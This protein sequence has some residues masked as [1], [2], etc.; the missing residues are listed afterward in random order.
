MSVKS[1]KLSPGSPRPIAPWLSLDT[2]G[3]LFIGVLCLAYAPLLVRLGRWLWNREHYSFFP[4]G[5][6]AV[7]GLLVSALAEPGDVLSSR[8]LRSVLL[9]VAFLLLLVATLFVSPWLCGVSAMFLLLGM[10]YAVGGPEVTKKA[11]PAWLLLWMLV[12]IPLSLDQELIVSL[13]HFATRLSS[14]ILDWMGYR[15]IVNGVVLRL[16]ERIYQVEEACSGVQSLFS[17]LFCTG[18]YLILNRAGIIRSLLLIS[19]TFFWVMVAN[20]GR[21]VCV[22][23]LKES[24]D[25]PVDQ[26]FYHA[27]LGFVFF[28]MTLV[29]I[30][31]TE[32]LF[33]FVWP[34]LVLPYWEYRADQKAVAP[35]KRSWR[36]KPLSD[37]FGPIEFNVVIAMFGLV[38]AA[39]CV[40]IALG[41]SM[42]GPSLSDIEVLASQGQSTIPEEIEG[43]K[44]TQYQYIKRQSGDVNGETS[45]LWILEKD[46]RRIE[47]SIDG[48]YTN[49]WHYL[50]DCYRGQGW[51]DGGTTYTSY[52]DIGED[53]GGDFLWFNVAKQPEEH[54]IVVTGL[55]DSENRAFV[56]PQVKKMQRHYGRLNDLKERV[57]SLFGMGDQTI[58][59]SD[60]TSYQIQ[61]FYHGANPVTDEDRQQCIELFHSLRKH[62]TNVE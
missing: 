62:I 30:F 12:P 32:R 16:P 29:A 49:G 5:I 7:T 23:T 9:R 10:I 8:W 15:H 40:S 17:A 41:G 6:L 59:R 44:Q 56:A 52:R 51:K 46:G 48:P 55:F 47:A 57:A 36:Q 45:K 33:N 42:A 26:G 50:S 11:L 19:T 13:Q 25:L 61:V 18:L 38:A 24:F 35:A 21:I 31:S 43:W 60:S 58:A 28:A 2:K 22:V 4:L 39:Q 27:M 54:G 1:N 20:I 3:F 37:F 53:R 14:G 34:T